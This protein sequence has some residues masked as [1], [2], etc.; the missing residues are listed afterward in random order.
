MADPVS[1]DTGWISASG[2][3]SNAASP[4]DD[5]VWQNLGNVTASDNA[6]ASATLNS[7]QLPEILNCAFSSLA[8][9][10]PVDATIDGVEVR[11]EGYS[12]NVYGSGPTIGLATNTS[13]NP[14]S[15]TQDF[16]I[17]LPYGSSAGEAYVSKGG[18]T[19]LW[20]A[21]SIAA[22]SLVDSGFRVFMRFGRISS[23]VV[24]YIDHVQIKVYYTYTPGDE[25]GVALFWGI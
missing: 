6:R 18:S 11:F 4:Y 12:S 7:S 9:V 3:T 15:G 8:A 23:N 14:V 1:T 2:A 17:L 10:V 16:Q 21:G 19:F 20:D 24:V 25:V 5:V 13:M 22:S